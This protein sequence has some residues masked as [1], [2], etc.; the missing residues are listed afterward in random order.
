MAGQLSPFPSC[1][2]GLGL[3]A[4]PDYRSTTS[5]LTPTASICTVSSLARGTDSTPDGSSHTRSRTKT[6]QTKEIL[7]SP[8]PHR[9]HL[10]LS[11]RRR[12][13]EIP[14]LPSRP[15]AQ[16]RDAWGPRSPV[17]PV[18]SDGFVG[19]DGKDIL[20][21]S[22][23]PLMPPEASDFE[24]LCPSSPGIQVSPDLGME[25][26]AGRVPADSLP[27]S[28][29]RESLVGSRPTSTGSA[30]STQTASG[31]FTLVH[32]QGSK[33]LSLASG[34]PRTDVYEETHLKG[35]LLG[36]K[37]FFCSPRVQEVEDA[38]DEAEGELFEPD[39]EPVHSE[40]VVSEQ[41]VE[42]DVL[43]EVIATTSSSDVAIPADATH[44]T[45]G[46]LDSLLSKYQSTTERLP[47]D[48][49]SSL[50]QP[51]PL[52]AA[53]SGSTAEQEHIT[54]MKQ[55][56]RGDRRKFALRRQAIYAEYG[57]QIALPDSD[58]DSS[59]KILASTPNK[60][61]KGHQL[62]AAS[63]YAL[64]ASHSGSRAALPASASRDPSARARFA[65]ISM[66]GV[67]DSVSD[68]AEE[69]DD[70]ALFGSANDVDRLG[71]LSVQDGLLSATRSPLSL[72]EGLADLTTS[73]PP[74]SVHSKSLSASHSRS[75]VRDTLGPG[76]GLG[77]SL[78][79]SPV[80]S[81][82][83]RSHNGHGSIAGLGPT[84]YLAAPRNPG[85]G[86]LHPSLSTLRVPSKD[87]QCTPLRVYKLSPAPFETNAHTQ[88]KRQSV[89]MPVSTSE[90]SA[91]LSAWDFDPG[92]HPIVQ[93][94]LNEVDRALE[95]WRW[96]LQLRA[97]AY[98]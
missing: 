20:H 30:F 21:S 73:T 90:R 48:T 6:M 36:E 80:L 72:L 52:P 38:V 63:A 40:L 34:T 5:L 55:S 60:N 57:F 56:T 75:L 64:P 47:E 65:H 87:T 37:P 3:M 67:G 2:S 96:I 10:V 74:R 16:L 61:K 50:L 62:R 88:P 41:P 93:D 84:T 28:A 81:P 24:Y 76:A 11:A 43:P 42:A 19:Q 46:T 35:S 49:P 1:S 14:S 33:R 98:V 18:G 51:T 71:R 82:A 58:S 26:D 53:V 12:T 83:S 23:S 4:S 32:D 8:R 44:A 17:S 45:S 9:F 69:D 39:M 89:C 13:P 79:P 86:P 54:P 27:F 77:L 29:F 59:I 68:L 22:E 95:Q 25:E 91:R 85:L 92:H 78:S 94:L 66:G 97:Y 70:L 31:S 7:K 15:S